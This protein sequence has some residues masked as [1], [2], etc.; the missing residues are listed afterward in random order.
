VQE[1]QGAGPQARMR[2]RRPS[3][4]RPA[5]TPSPTG[6]LVSC[7]YLARED[8]NGVLGAAVAAVDPAHRCTALADAVPQSPRQQELVCL[9]AA[10]ANCPRYLRG[11]QLAETPAPPT[12]RQPISPAIL[13]AAL[14]FAAAIAASFGFLAVRGGFELALATSSPSDVAAAPTP[15]GT[16]ALG[17]GSPGPGL[18][19]PPTAPASTAPSAPAPTP[20][21]ATSTAPT[22]G[23]TPTPTPGPTPKPKPSSDR[24]ALLTAC[25]ARS[26]CWIYVIRSGDNLV[27]IANWFGVDYDRVR[28]MN[29][30]LRIPIHAGDRLRIPT[31]TR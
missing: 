9:T 10:H 16:T 21:P 25:P 6:D 19:A 3:P 7:P 30:N 17:I 23:P 2:A 27:S 11:R 15:A 18:S 24:Y 14:V 26:D 28:A 22:P 13:I 31:P 20:S 1:G 29:P 8:A 5:P 4:F 12:G